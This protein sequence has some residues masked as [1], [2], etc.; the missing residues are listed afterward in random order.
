MYILTCLILIF[1]NTSMNT[2]HFFVYSPH[3][4]NLD[5]KGTHL[6]RITGS[7]LGKYFMLHSFATLM[8]IIILQN[9]L[10]FFV[11]FLLSHLISSSFSAT[12]QKPP[13]SRIRII[14]C[15]TCKTVDLLGLLSVM[16]V[17]FHPTLLWN[18]INLVCCTFELRNLLGQ[19]S[20]SIHR[21]IV[22]PSEFLNYV[23]APCQAA[24]PMGIASKILQ[25]PI[26]DE[27]DQ[28]L[29]MHG[30]Q[31]EGPLHMTF[32]VQ[33]RSMGSRVRPDEE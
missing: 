1:I 7:I 21:Y 22:I 8:I 32:F 27:V 25:V 30:L 12:S 26:V 31:V 4:Q 17:K 18:I 14:T 20:W 11:H 10:Q 16:Y 13:P 33:R 15:L 29:S 2:L 9:T 23:H 6:F 19:L 24:T 3:L 5:N 28:I